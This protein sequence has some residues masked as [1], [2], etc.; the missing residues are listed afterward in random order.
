MYFHNDLCFVKICASEER[1]TFVGPHGILTLRGGTTF[2]SND[3]G[4]YYSSETLEIFDSHLVIPTLRYLTHKQAHV[5]LGSF[6]AC[7]S[8]DL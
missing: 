1:A 7:L 4:L 2:L 5:N 8:Q 3:P 6:H